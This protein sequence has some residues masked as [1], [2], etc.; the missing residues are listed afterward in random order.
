MKFTSRYNSS[1]PDFA[2]NN[3]DNTNIYKKLACAAVKIDE[4][5]QKRKKFHHL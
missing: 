2:I 3:S 1:S 5:S 4:I